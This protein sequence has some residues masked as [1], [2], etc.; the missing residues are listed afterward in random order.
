MSDRKKDC[1]RF[2][3]EWRNL[4]EATL[5]KLNKAKKSYQNIEVPEELEERIKNIIQKS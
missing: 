2:D 4:L 3:T 1:V 5:P